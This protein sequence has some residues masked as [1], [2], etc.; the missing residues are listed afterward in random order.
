MS[1]PIFSKHLT[2]QVI[3]EGLQKRWVM[4]GLKMTLVG[5]LIGW[6]KGAWLYNI[7]MQPL[8]MNNGTL[9]LPKKNAEWEVQD[10]NIHMI[11]MHFKTK[12]YI[13]LNLVYY[14]N[15][16]SPVEYEPHY[17]SGIPNYM[18]SF[19]KNNEWKE[20]RKINQTE[21]LQ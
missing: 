2:K 6:Y 1:K 11:P 9:K 10:K 4:N 12:D 7:D 18:F 20:T 3:K 19:R 13:Y 5:S 21:T 15:C 14:D 8:E 16:E 17:A